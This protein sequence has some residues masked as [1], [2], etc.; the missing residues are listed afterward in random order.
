MLNF[1]RNYVASVSFLALCC[2]LPAIAQPSLLSTTVSAQPKQSFSAFVNQA[3]LVTTQLIQQTDNSYS[4]TVLGERNGNITP[5]FFQDAQ[6]IKYFPNAAV[7]LGFTKP[8]V[9]KPTKPSPEESIPTDFN[10]EE[11]SEAIILPETE[12]EMNNF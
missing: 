3:A 1:Q 8:P 9:A 6:Q 12:P 10:T 2:P 4:I 7:L 11:E 5:I